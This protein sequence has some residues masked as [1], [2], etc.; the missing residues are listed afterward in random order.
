MV[1]EYL[2]YFNLMS[3]VGIAGMHLTHND[4]SWYLTAILCLNIFLI[5]VS[6]LVID[7]KSMKR[8][9]KIEQLERELDELREKSNIVTV[10]GFR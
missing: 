4:V 5:T 9:E 8:D 3:A 7:W 1:W 10:I 2:L 6:C